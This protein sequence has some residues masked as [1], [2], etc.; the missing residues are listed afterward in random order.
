MKRILASAVLLSSLAVAGTAAAQFVGPG[1]YGYVG[2]SIG[3]NNYAT[4]ITCAGT[5]DKTD[6]M[7]KIFGGYM[8]NPYWGI[9]AA[10]GGFGTMKANFQDGG[11]NVLA[12]VKSSGF[13]GFLVGQY[14]IDNF[15]LFGK[16]GFAY[17]DTKVTLTV[18]GFGS[19]EDS[20]NSTEFAWGIGGTYMFNKNLGVRL[21][22][23]QLKYK[24]S[25]FNVPGIGNAIEGSDKMR[26]WSIGVQ[27][28]F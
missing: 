16:L 2:A 10:Y 20:D 22:Y 7:G 8:F 11:T 21:E 3:Q 14:P 18:P 9:E 4:D 17:V 26:M 25:G 15:R 12:E 24:F 6:T 13:S 28:N 27:Y 5:C 23:E 1:A 19:A